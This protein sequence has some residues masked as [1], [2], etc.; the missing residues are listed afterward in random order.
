MSAPRS[1]QRLC[2]KDGIRVADASLRACQNSRCPFGRRL[3]CFFCFRRGSNPERVSGGKGHAGGMSA[4]R[5]PQRLCRKDGIRAADAS[6]RACQNS[7]CPF[8]RRLFC[9]FCFR[10]D[11][12]PE[13]VSGGKGHAGGMSAPRSPQRLC[14]KDGI[15][16]ADASLRAYPSSTLRAA[17]CRRSRRFFDS[18]QKSRLRAV[19]EHGTLNGKN[20]HCRREES[21]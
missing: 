12:N 2:R 19:R 7:R 18:W 13:R 14:R 15:R 6:L 16:T 10:R 4:P 9:F 20:G 17:E 8:G 21:P 5:S 11:S 1:P 3:F